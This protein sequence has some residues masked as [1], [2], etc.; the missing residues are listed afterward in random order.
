M[1]E[2][3]ESFEGW[4]ERK[5]PE[6]FRRQRF[7][8]RTIEAW[9]DQQEKIE[10]RDKKIQQLIEDKTIL[11]REKEALE[12]QLKEARSIADSFQERYSHACS[13]IKA[14]EK[15]QVEKVAEIEKMRKE[16]VKIREKSF[17]FQSYIG[18]NMSSEVAGFACDIVYRCDD[19]LGELEE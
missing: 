19:A 17:P 6:A 2:D 4:F 12:K 15:F 13:E 11:S 1:S 10:L 9:F 8:K 3:S 14:L 18:E 16:L 5:F 7:G